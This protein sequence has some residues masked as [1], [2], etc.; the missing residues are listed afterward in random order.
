MQTSFPAARRAGVDRD[1]P[2]RIL[3]IASRLVQTRGFNG[4][5]YAD[6]AA[7]LAVTKASLHYHFPSKAEL[8]RHLIDRYARAF[9]TALD[10]IDAG[11]ADEFDKLQ[12]YAQM[13]ATVLGEHRMCLCGM[14]AAESATL[15]EP[16]REALKRFFELNERWLA[17]VLVRGRRK[18]QVSFAGAPID[19]ARMLVGALEGAMM[20]AHSLADAAR[21]KAAAAR[22]L[23]DFAPARAPAQ[24]GAAKPAALS[25][26]DPS[27]RPRRPRPAAAR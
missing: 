27:S 26:P 15:P 11:G 19:A 9:A 21:F 22:L 3:D 14:L 10:R 16:M 4:F 2:Q 23:A 18:G 20:L 8:G 13:Y 24:R 25:A 17:A 1:T 12:R 5:S 7:E 6:I